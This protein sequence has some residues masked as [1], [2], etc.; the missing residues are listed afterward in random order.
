MGSGE[1]AITLE[2]RDT[3][4]LTSPPSN[5][6][7]ASAGKVFRYCVRLQTGDFEE[8]EPRRSFPLSP[9]AYDS[10]L[11]LLRPHPLLFEYISKSRYDYDACNSVITFRLASRTHMSFV[12]RVRRA[13]LVH[14]AGCQVR[15]PELASQIDSLDDGSPR[16]ALDL[17]RTIAEFERNE[18][19]PDDGDKQSSYVPDL[20]FFHE[21][22]TDPILI[23]EVAYSQTTVSLRRVARNYITGSRGAIKKVV[24]LKLEYA[25][26]K[27]ATISV[28][29]P[30]VI[31]EP[32]N[33]ELTAYPE[34]SELASATSLARRVPTPRA[35]SLCCNP[36]D[37]EAL[38]VF[39][40]DQGHAVPGVSLDFILSDFFPMKV[41]PLLSPHQNLPISISSADLCEWLDRRRNQDR[42]SGGEEVNRS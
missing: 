24:G 3:Q 22:F 34:I 14:M 40:D 39:R 37:T 26:S 38:K 35:D 5:S 1:L 33:D 25:G 2:D 6:S 42:S 15:F 21:H 17:S 11:E 20:A 23:I 31:G 10:F 18:D 7:T 9:E 41:R 8:T 32:G 36:T 29:V 13:I 12:S 28:W 30:R 4:L 19:D 27:K 16:V